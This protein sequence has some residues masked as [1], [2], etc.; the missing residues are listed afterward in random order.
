MT[1]DVKNIGQTVIWWTDN[2]DID[3]LYL[4]IPS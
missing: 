2:Q 3:N 4:L 1:D